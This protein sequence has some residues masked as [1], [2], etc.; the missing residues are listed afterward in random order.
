MIRNSKCAIQNTFWQ[1]T[2]G[3]L[4]IRLINGCNNTLMS[5]LVC[6]VV[7]ECGSEVDWLIS[8]HFPSELQVNGHTDIP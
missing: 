4:Y 1:L 6:M 3:K 8:L 2:N 7:P 5:F